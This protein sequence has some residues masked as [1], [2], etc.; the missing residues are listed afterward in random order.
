MCLWEGLPN[1]KREHNCC[2]CIPA[3]VQD[4]SIIPRSAICKSL[5]D[6]ILLSAVF[7]S[8]K[9]V[10]LTSV[11]LD[12]PWL[13]SSEELYWDN[14]SQPMLKA[15]ITGYGMYAKITL[16]WMGLID[17]VMYS[18]VVWKCCLEN[19]RDNWFSNLF[20][21]IIMLKEITLPKYQMYLL[22]HF[23]MYQPQKSVNSACL[24]VCKKI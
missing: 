2:Y 21:I 23:W 1:N 4:V 8:V 9:H 12:S 10:L 24:F 19:W 6:L 13:H 16:I 18:D 20:S 17:K 5:E 3:N 22:S 14:F 15:Y 11:L 7:Q